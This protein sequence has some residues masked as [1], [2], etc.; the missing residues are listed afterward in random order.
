MIDGVCGGIA[1]YFSVD[2]TLVR[3]LWVLLTIFGGSGVLLYIAA[4]IVMPKEDVA[5]PTEAAPPKNHTQNTRFWGIL[6]VVV[7]AL[8]LLGNLGVP[9]WH[10][11]WGFPLHIG[12]PVLLIL[13]GAAFLFGGRSYVSA[14]TVPGAGPEGQAFGSAPSFTAPSEPERL[15]RSRTDKKIMGVC[16]GI[17]AHVNVDPVIVRLL[18]VAGLLASCGFF[19]LLYIIMGIIIPQEPAAATTA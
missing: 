17:G 12:V 7:G 5:A 10:H 19:V 16:G 11:W 3:I 14:Q 4:M 8:W 1:A 13:A 6:L 15:Y 9:I 2:A 18:F